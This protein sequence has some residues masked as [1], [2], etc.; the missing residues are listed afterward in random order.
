MLEPGEQPSER[1]NELQDEPSRLALG[2]HEARHG[3]EEQR[4]ADQELDLNGPRQIGERNGLHQGEPILGAVGSATAVAAA[5]VKTQRDGRV[6]TVRLDNPPHNFMTSAMVG[7]LDALSRE[8]EDDRSIGAVI[9]T[10]AAGGA[11]ITHYDVAELLADAEALATTVS[12][13]AARGSLR[14]VGAI[15][16]I[17]GGRAALERSPAAGVLDLRAIHALFDRMGRMDKVW[18]AAVNG[19]AT[20]GGCE[21]ALACDIR[22][23]ALGDHRIGQPEIALGLIPGGGGT[24]RLARALGP[25][26][27]LELILEGRLLAP[28]EALGVGLVHR[29]VSPERLEEAARGTAR[30]LARR[31]PAAVRAAK[32]AVYDGASRPLAQG[33]H[34]ERASFLA[35]AST[36]A[37]RRAMAAYAA[38]VRDGGGVPIR[39]DYER[40]R[41]GTAVDLTD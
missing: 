1:R 28:E 36:A 2:E 5:T 40:W 26:A 21:L 19:M 17:P 7:E 20:G 9:V 27:A 4:P 29:V 38:E 23:M 12:P 6:L 25:A 41:D 30:R 32:R 34:F 18:V 14:A 13:A 11:F 15:A 33:L 37:A 16:R 31:S 35:S 8:L 39:D 3:A 10:G 22:I 24:Q